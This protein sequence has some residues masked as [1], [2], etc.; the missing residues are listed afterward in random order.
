MAKRLTR[1]KEDFVTFRHD[2]DIEALA[3][4]LARAKGA[5]A[6]VEWIER[7]LEKYN[8]LQRANITDIHEL[9]S[10]LREYL[11]HRAEARGDDPV[12]VAERELIGK[13]LPGFFPT[14]RPIIEMLLERADI[15]EQ[16][17]VL[18][19]SCGKGDIL[20][21]FKPSTQ[22]A[23][24]TPSSSIGRCQTFFRPKDT[25]WSLRISWSIANTTTG[26]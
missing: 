3:D 12:K 13:K 18:E 2:H 20:D 1:E 8:R 7:A 10:A 26:L 14:P 9:R 22:A 25:K 11:C 15:G 19:P 17:R 23:K 6:N 16:H 5:G 24:F 4:F 21:A